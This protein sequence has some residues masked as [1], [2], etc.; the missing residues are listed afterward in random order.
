[1]TL[2]HKTTCRHGRPRT[3]AIFPSRTLSLVLD[4]Y[5]NDAVA[6][7][8]DSPQH[9]EPAAAS[10]SASIGSGAHRWH[11]RGQSVTLLLGDQDSFSSAFC[12]RRSL[13]TV[14]TCQGAKMAG[15]IRSLFG[16]FAANTHDPN[17]IVRKALLSSSV[18]PECLMP[19]SPA[20]SANVSC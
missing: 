11:S 13:G 19:V 4:P 16:P 9:F 10:L 15:V 3:E 18:F 20:R 1:M 14:T 8:T 2:S 5:Q 6:E 17:G 7:T 12:P